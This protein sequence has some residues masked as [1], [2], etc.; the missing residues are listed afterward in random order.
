MNPV[1]RLKSLI[2]GL[3]PEEE[4]L[5]ARLT[6]LVCPGGRNGNPGLEGKGSGMRLRAQIVVTLTI[7]G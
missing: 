7:G 4:N 3:Q 6:L 1:K 5:N 2:V